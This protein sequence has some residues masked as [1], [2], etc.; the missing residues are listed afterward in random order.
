MAPQ[1]AHR[2]PSP[3]P[4]SAHKRSPSASSASAAK[5]SCGKHY[6]SPASPIAALRFIDQIDF[7]LWQAAGNEAAVLEQLPATLANDLQVAW[8][9]P[10]PPLIIS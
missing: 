3:S 9:T 7:Y 4:L 8:S 5:R 10:P 6:T 1:Q 2:R